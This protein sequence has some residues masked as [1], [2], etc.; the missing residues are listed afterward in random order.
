MHIV[1]VVTNKPVTDPFFSAVKGE[2]VAKRFLSEDDA[3]GWIDRYVA[4]GLWYPDTGEF[5]K[6]EDFEIRSDD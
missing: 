1:N 2:P 6:H 4:R 5:I 3:N